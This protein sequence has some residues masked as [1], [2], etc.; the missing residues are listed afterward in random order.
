ML[1][2]VA[3]LSF[4][5]DPFTSPIL[6]MLLALQVIEVGSIKPIPNGAQV[7]FTIL[8]RCLYFER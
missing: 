3:E 4:S 8:C 1:E 7:L 5:H 2:P 6:P